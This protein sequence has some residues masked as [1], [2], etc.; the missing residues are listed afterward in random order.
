[1]WDL[2]GVGGGAGGAGG[3]EVRRARGGVGDV[4]LVVGAVEVDAV[5]ASEGC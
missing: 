1:M 2:D 5:P 4:I 3:E